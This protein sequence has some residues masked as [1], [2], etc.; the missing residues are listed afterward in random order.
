MDLSD[1]TGLQKLS[2]LGHIIGK[3]IEFLSLDWCSTV[4]GCTHTCTLNAEVLYAAVGKTFNA[5]IYFIFQFE[6]NLDRPEDLLKQKIWEM[7]K[8]EIHLKQQV[9]DG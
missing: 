4:L 1:W 3:R 5:A 6:N 2:C 9:H 7:E 8:L